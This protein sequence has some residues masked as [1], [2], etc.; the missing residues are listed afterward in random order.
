MSELIDVA[1]ANLMLDVANPRF[2]TEQE[3]QRE[4]IRR[5][6]EDQGDKLLN[7]AEDITS[8][9]LDPSSRALII[10]HED[11]KRFVVVEGNRRV[12]A[13]K[14]LRNPELVKG[15]W[16]ATQE[17]R[18]DELGS[19][20]VDDP[21]NQ[22]PC[23]LLPDR[24]TAD[25][26]L[27]LR[28]R[29]EQGGRGIVA[30]DGL[31]ATR[32][33]QRRGRGRAVAALEAVDL[34]RD[35]GGL[36]Q[37]TL[38][39]LG[40]IPITTVQRVLNDPRMR[41]AIGIDLLKGKLALR[42]PESEA[43]KGL[44]RVIHD[45]AHGLLPVSRVDTQADRKRYLKDF[46]KADLPSPGTPETEPQLVHTGEPGAP[47]TRRRPIAPTK[48]RAVLIPRDFVLQIPDP[49]A[50]DIYHE[51]RN[52]KLRLED[53]PNAVSVLLR[54]FLELSVDHYIL[55]AKLMT[56]ADLDA[57]TMSLRKKLTQV[58]N[59]MQTAGSMTKRELT[60]VRRVIDPQH[61]LAGSVDTLHAYVH[62][63]NTVASPS[64]L[65][66]AWTGL[67]PFFQRLWA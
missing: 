26:W 39:R 28:H 34:V 37:G 32:F 15:I 58:A 54:V 27:W 35:R 55:T 41:K 52:N 12:A 29:G 46:R 59:H 22:V 10:A 21:V 17:R 67:A 24:E 1:P 63:A 6:A 25:H 9:G 43:L 56:K 42:V 38:D 36:D 53:F 47:P 3:D 18:L 14:L 8:H 51:L 33:E 31:E 60:P 64:D 2:E 40:D 57:T 48:K 23:V 30:W 45:A 11:G 44:T 19:K 66:A 65:R 49:K 61:F 16:S 62:D 7:L 4:A 5:M 20:F 13:I 50:N